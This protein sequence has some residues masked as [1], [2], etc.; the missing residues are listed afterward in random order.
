MKNLAKIFKS[1]SFFLRETEFR[2]FNTKI[3]HQ[4][5]LIYKSVH[6]TVA[7]PFLRREL[8]QILE[9]TRFFYEYYY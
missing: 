2:V 6:M 7:H 8:P 4:P 1:K 3:F 9:F 5:S